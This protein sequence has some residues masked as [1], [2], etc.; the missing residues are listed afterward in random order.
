VDDAEFDALSAEDQT[1][2]YY[3]AAHSTAA[4]STKIAADK[5]TLLAHYVTGKDAEDVQLK[6]FTNVQP[7]A[8]SVKD[9]V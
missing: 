5:A 1:S 8:E 2:W 6:R 3:F 9:E 7:Q 4:S